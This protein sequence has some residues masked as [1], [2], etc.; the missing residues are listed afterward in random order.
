MRR[1][2]Q[3][4]NELKEIDRHIQAWIDAVSFDPAKTEVVVDDSQYV[5]AE[6]RFTT[7]ELVAHFQ[8]F[9]VPCG[10]VKSP[11]EM[12]ADPQL[13]HRKHYWQLEHPT[14]GLRSYDG[15]AFRLSETPGVLRK[16]AP[17]LGADNEYVY[18]DLIGLDEDE[19]VELLT[20]GALD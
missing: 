15:P 4:L 13:E 7:D 18:R 2:W 14:M 6:W 1:R 9:G 20:G 3:R 5:S 16:A 17:L 11:E 19:F 8:R 10:S 12:R